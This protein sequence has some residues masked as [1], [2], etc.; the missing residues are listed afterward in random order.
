M[1]QARRSGLRGGQRLV[2]LGGLAVGVGALLIGFPALAA[3]QA[4]PPDDLRAVDDEAATFVDTPIVIDVTA[5]DTLGTDGQLVAVGDVTRYGTATVD[6]DQVRYE[7]SAGFTGTD[8]FTYDICSASTTRCAS[9]R[10]TVEVVAWLHPYP[11]GPEDV[12]VQVV[13]A[14]L[15]T[16]EVTGA[17]VN[18][19][20]AV[21]DAAGRRFETR[22][23]PEGR[24][25]LVNDPDAPFTSGPAV[26]TVTTV[27]YMSVR[28]DLDLT[29]AQ[30]VYHHAALTPAAGPTVDEER[31][32]TVTTPPAP[33]RTLPVTGS[34]LA[35]TMAAAV[36]L[37]ASGTLSLHAAGRARNR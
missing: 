31:A 13:V 6:G 34:P 8:W 33:L 2:A 9:A 16:D 7:P 14:G 4:T 11:E 1:M 10:V 29:L 36:L 17:P 30:T 19:F 27:D 21:V 24:W 25:Q 22:T 3:G 32:P 18:A 20:V 12:V 5:N 23:D 28:A 35:L 26:L 15:V 37:I